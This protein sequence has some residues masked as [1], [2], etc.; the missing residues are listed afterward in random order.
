MNE[1]RKFFLLKISAVR[2]DWIVMKINLNLWRTNQFVAFICSI[3]SASAC[4]DCIQVV[5]LAQEI[6]LQKKT[7]FRNLKMYRAVTFCFWWI[8]WTSHRPITR[9]FK[10]ITDGGVVTIV[11]FKVFHIFYFFLISFNNVRRAVRNSVARFARS[12]VCSFI[13]FDSF[14]NL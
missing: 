3:E 1:Y 13:D 14:S 8:S 10:L 5:L 9:F 2:I 4:L 12:L 11:L 7:Y 6:S